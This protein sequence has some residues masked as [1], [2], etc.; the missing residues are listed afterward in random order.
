MEKLFK[1]SINRILKLEKKVEYLIDD[2]QDSEEL[3]K[4]VFTS[5]QLEVQELKIENQKLNVYY[6]SFI[7]I[8]EALK[9]DTDERQKIS[10]KFLMNMALATLLKIMKI[11]NFIL[12][13]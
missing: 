13:I 4:K 7:K 12:Y 1:T 3:Y 10:F 5:L 9:K 8:Y 2:N 11:I 6:N